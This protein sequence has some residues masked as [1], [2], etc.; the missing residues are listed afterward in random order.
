M[1]EKENAI[2]AWRNE[3]AH[4]HG[5]VTVCANCNQCDIH[6]RQGQFAG[7]YCKSM[8]NFLYKELGKDFGL[9]DC[10]V[11]ATDYCDDWESYK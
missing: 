6:T 10:S 8:Y 1:T 11:L 5:H 3:N 2:A 4:G 7:Y 9:Q